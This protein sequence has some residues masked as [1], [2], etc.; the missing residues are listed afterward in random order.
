MAAK[1]SRWYVV[2]CKPR[3]EARAWE[4]LHRQGFTCYLPTLRVE[5]RRH[6]RPVRAEEPLFPRYLFIQLD[7]V[8]QNW[9]P[10]RSTRGVLGLVR[11][12]DDPLPV[13]EEVVERIQAQLTV[14]QS[15]VRGLAPG[16]RVCMTEGPFARLEAI[17]L[18]RDGADRA[19]LLM[20]ILQCEQTLNV[21]ITSVRKVCAIG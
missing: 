18:A 20:E 2:Y 13:P 17:F 11:F 9:A 14:E 12:H 4:N 3:E 5:K 15:L 6:G 16:D 1:H 8:E 21:P 10:I 19:V 7:E